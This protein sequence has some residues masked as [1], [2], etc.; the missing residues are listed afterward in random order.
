MVT[1]LERSTP[2]TRRSLELEPLI[3]AVRSALH[4]HPSDADAAA[5]VA[6]CLSAHAPSID[7]LSPADQLGDA[8]HY[9]Q[10]VLYVDRDVTFSIVA[11]VWQAGQRTTIHDHLCWG[12]VRVLRGAELETLYSAV[13]GRTRTHLVPLHQRVNPTGDVSFFA[14]P[15]DIHYV[16]NPG[17]TTAISLHVYG[18]DIAAAGSSIR[19]VYDVRQVTG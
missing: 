15:G 16:C 10:H 11:L 9:Q 12:A 1:V 3:D 5:R 17:P 8:D 14:P 4:D 18:A 13:P 2:S 7:I 6:G 19:R